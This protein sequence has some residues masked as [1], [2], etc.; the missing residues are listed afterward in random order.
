MPDEAKR[1]TW[2]L[3]TKLKASVPLLPAL[4]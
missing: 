3:T 4:P 2:A 1:G